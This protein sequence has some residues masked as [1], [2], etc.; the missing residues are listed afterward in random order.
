VLERPQHAVAHSW[1][2]AAA[3]NLGETEAARAALAEF[4]RRL[5]S[6]TISSFRDER[7]CANDLCRSQ[8]ERYYAGLA[9]AGLP[10]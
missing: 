9:K 5:P 8:R 3:A 2:A 10:E 7:L 6:Y 4:R 1:V